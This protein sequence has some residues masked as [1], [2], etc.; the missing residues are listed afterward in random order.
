MKTL[1]DRPDMDQLRQQAKDLL[2][3]LRHT[4]P[5][6]TLARA[7]AALAGQ[8][9]FDSW[10]SLKAEVDR[11]AGHG[12]EVDA[13]IA[14][15]LAARFD[16]GEVTRP[17]TSLAPPDDTGRR[18]TLV[19]D[20]GRFE[21]RTLDTWWPIVDAAATLRV[22]LAAAAAGVLLP[23]PVLGVGGGLVEEVG[24]HRWWVHEHI[25]S[26]PP[27][28]A[29]VSPAVARQAGEALAAIH[30]LG[31]AVD[32]VSPWSAGRLDAT[33]WADVAAAA[34]A[35]RASWADALA[36][37]VPLLAHLE[38]LGSDVAPEPPVLSH[39]GLGPGQCRLRADGRLVVAA[40]EHAGGQPP[41]WELADAL[42]NWAVEPRGAA[43]DAAARALAGGYRERA[44]G[45]PE[46]DLAAFRG[47]AT[48]LLNYLGGLVG[49][50]LADE[51]TPGSDVDR[52]VAHLLAHLP[53]TA[54]YGRLLAAIAPEMR[55]AAV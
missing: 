15:E 34:R 54:T 47:H 28:S 17:M 38:A 2:A 7:Q 52:S 35:H 27:L 4:D 10:T 40:W 31:L 36:E 6:T 5:T 13:A 14:R 44:G 46:L 19:T 30:G 1:P 45:L 22:Q 51:A 25:P 49:M 42:A 20:R 43:N 55:P 3:G 11:R 12:I 21:A 33:P 9:G 48:G 8:Y 24:G 26:G 16:L 50:V 53:T 37:A 29:P 23:T 18:H 41:S 32:R 39:N